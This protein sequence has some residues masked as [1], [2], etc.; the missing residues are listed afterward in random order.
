[1]AKTAPM[2]IPA[3]PIGSRPRFVDL[4]ERVAKGD[5]E[6]P[7]L[8]PLYENAIRDT[9]ERFEARQVLKVIRKHLKPNQRIFVGVIT[10]IDR[11]LEAP[12]EVRVRSFEPGENWRWCYVDG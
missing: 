8:A 1:M 12:E 6:D 2:S 11:Y 5:S 9:I 10:P 3:E 4:I 7:D